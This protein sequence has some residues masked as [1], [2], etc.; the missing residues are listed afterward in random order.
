MDEQ[1]IVFNA[2]AKK[3]KRPC[4]DCNRE[5]SGTGRIVLDKATGHAFI[6]FHC[7]FTRETFPIYRPDQQKLAEELAR[8]ILGADYPLP[9]GP[10]AK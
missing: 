2:K 8:E 1:L 7:P 5:I 6:E 9:K 10:A 3:L 4:P